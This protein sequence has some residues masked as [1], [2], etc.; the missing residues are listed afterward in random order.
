MTESRHHTMPKIVKQTYHQTTMIFADILPVSCGKWTFS[1]T[2]NA[3]Y[4]MVVQ[5]ITAAATPD[6]RASRS[7]PTPHL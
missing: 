1:S 4:W 6:Q 7:Q 2:F 5:I 3:F